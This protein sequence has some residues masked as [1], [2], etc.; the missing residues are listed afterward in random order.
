MTE[1]PGS[2][3]WGD[4]LPPGYISLSEICFT[5]VT[6]ASRCAPPRTPPAPPTPPRRPPPRG[7][8]RAA[9]PPPPAVALATRG[10]RNPTGSCIHR[11]FV[12]RK[13]RDRRPPPCIDQ[14]ISASAHQRISASAHQR[15]SASAHQRIS[16]SAH[17]RN[18]CRIERKAPWPPPSP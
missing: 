4:G 12:K 16:A 7:G 18:P 3:G 1:P 13:A 5:I 15:I 2:R 9:R 17:Q 14:R 10:E 6:N 8:R 11:P